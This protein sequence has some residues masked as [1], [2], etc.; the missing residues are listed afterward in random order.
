M[1]HSISGTNGDDMKR[2]WTW[3]EEK[4]D[5]EGGELDFSKAE[6]EKFLV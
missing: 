4:L 2:S 5:L 6:G 3:G 1:G